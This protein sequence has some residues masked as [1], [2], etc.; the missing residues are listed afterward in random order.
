MTGGLSISQARDAVINYREVRGPAVATT[1]SSTRATQFA[2]TLDGRGSESASV[3][4]VGFVVV[5]MLR[6]NAAI[7]GPPRGYWAPMPI[8][9]RASQLSVRR[10]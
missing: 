3:A 2:G 10:A 5:G 9:S 6:D 1:A 4:A 7:V 8:P